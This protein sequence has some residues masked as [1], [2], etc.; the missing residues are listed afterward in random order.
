[1]TSEVLNEFRIVVQDRTIY[2]GRATVRSAVNTGQMVVCEATLSESSWQDLSFSP[3]IARNGHV[4]HLLQSFLQEW[5]KLY[6]IIPEYKVIIADMQSFLMDFRL[7]CD[8]LELGLRTASEKERPELEE[9]LVTEL[10]G[11]LLPCVDSLFDK[12]ETIALGL[13][14]EVRPAHRSYM[15]RQLHPLILCA[16]FAFRTYEKPLGYA[17]DYEMVNM[18]VRNRHE[19][20]SLYAK[21]VNTWFLRQAP[22]AAH[23]NRVDYLKTKLVE[24]TARGVRAGRPARILNL[25]CGPAGEVQQFLKESP[26]SDHARF[27]L[28]DFND[29]TIEYAQRAVGEALTRHRRHAQIQFQKKSVLHVLK[30]AVKQSAPGVQYDFVYCAGLFDYLTDRTCKQLLDALY[31]WTAPG[32]LL[33][34]TNVEPANPMRNGMEHLLDWNLIYRTA[35][36]MRIIKPQSATD[37]NSA[38]YSDS[39]GVNVFLEVRKPA[40]G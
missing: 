27:T 21:L 7:W 30:E 19:G 26:L 29:E 28:L 6:K 39:T 9:K 14:E 8:Q 10:A 36:E 17:G 12:F 38:V 20:G 2:S 3:A 22:A 31:S 24:E 32:G 40:H 25:G 13:S 33:V 34:A 11:P 5:Q 37:D 18:I 23:R 1:R 15:R 16:P 4:P 35:H